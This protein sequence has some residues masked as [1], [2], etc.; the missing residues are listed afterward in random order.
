MKKWIVVFV[1][2]IFVFAGCDKK[3]PVVVYADYLAKEHIPYTKDME[4]MEVITVSEDYDL[5]I[6]DDSEYSRFVLF[7][8]DAKVKNFEFFTI[9]IPV[10]DTVEYHME[11]PV[12]HYDDLSA[13]KSL[14][15][16]MAMPET[17]PWYGISYTDENGDTVRFAI[18]TS[19][20][21]DSV[22]LEKF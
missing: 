19:G 11:K 6:R 14:I 20:Y 22:I 12:L 21:D 17:F 8:T 18:C 1:V 3:E 16:Q 2:A 15:I 13:N 10:G 5:F 7:S 4:R 9:A